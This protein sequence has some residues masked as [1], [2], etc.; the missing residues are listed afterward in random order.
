MH[1]AFPVQI[2]KN[3]DE[4]F[5]LLRECSKGHVIIL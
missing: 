5:L 2:N 1:T 3:L 4:P